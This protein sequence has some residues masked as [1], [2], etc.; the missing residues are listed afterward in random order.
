M[1][2]GFFHLNLKFAIPFIAVTGFLTFI[3][4]SGFSQAAMG[5]AYDVQIGTVSSKGKVRSLAQKYKQL[6]APIYT[7]SQQGGWKLIA[8]TNTS[9]Q[10]A[11]SFVDRWLSGTGAAPIES[12]FDVAPNGALVKTGIY[13][14]YQLYRYVPEPN[15][16]AN[17]QKAQSPSEQESRR[18]TV[19][20]LASTPDPDNPS[21]SEL[22]ALP[23]RAPDLSARDLVRLARNDDSTP[24]TDSEVNSSQDPSNEANYD[25]TNADRA[26]FIEVMADY[27]FHEYE[28]N[29]FSNGSPE[30]ARKMA[31]YYATWIFDAARLYSLDPF[32]MVAIPNHETNFMNVNGDLDHF[33]N[34]V[35]NH[36]EG[37]FQMLKTTQLEVYQDM[38]ERG[39]AGL[40]TWRP[41][42][43][44]KKFPRDQAYMAAHFLR[45]FCEAYPKN[46]RNALTIYNGSPSYPPKV[47]QKLDKVARFYT[48][49]TS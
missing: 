39:L 11:K 29:A 6:G 48:Q 17:N 3:P 28:N 7:L 10:R 27:I 20:E 8:D 1:H 32:L 34:G 37:I 12:A 13:P 42:Q 49:Q 46:Y 40:I 30:L 36:S 23:P 33:T 35:R 5:Q 22:A 15:Q 47:F 38:K 45:F 16:S 44:L 14:A 43:D 25:A 2:K 9:H 21:A 19:R 18:I 31:F 26:Q 41:G 4:S 24:D